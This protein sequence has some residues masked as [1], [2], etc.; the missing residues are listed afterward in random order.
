MQAFL[1]V[2]GYFS[3]NVDK[4]RAGAFKNF[5]IPYVIF[6]Y[7]VYFER[8]ALYGISNCHPHL[9][10]P[11]FALWFLVV[12]FVYRFFIKNL[13][14]VPGLVLWSVALYFASAYIPFL[15]EDLA[16]GRICAFFMF[17]VLGYKMT[18]EHVEKIKAIPHWIMCIVVAALVAF[19]YYMACLDLPGGMEILL[20]RAP[21]TSF[22]FPVVDG[23]FWR[24][25]IAIVALLWIAAFINLAPT[26][27]TRLTGL[28]QRTMVVYILH[29]FVRNLIKYFGIWG[30]GNVI[31]YIITFG[32][33]IGCLYIFQLPI[34]TK[35]YNTGLDWISDNLVKLIPKRKANEQS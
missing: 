35:W 27:K 17:Y 7:L 1:F 16:G 9:F 4:C 23:F 6:C 31:Y 28:G 12:M 25:V 10:H 29:I 8:G 34:L 2:S 14:K 32:L 15:N 26:K 21:F 5:I 30:H 33:A 24:F 11:T 20:L 3:K 19:C 18:K 22:G 13:S